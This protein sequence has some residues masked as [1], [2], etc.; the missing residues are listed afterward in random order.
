MSTTIIKLIDNNIIGAV[1]APNGTAHPYFDDI[2]HKLEPIRLTRSEFAA[3]KQFVGMIGP[4][5]SGK[6]T[7]INSLIGS[8]V[9][10]IGGGT[11]TTARPSLV[12][13][14]RNP[15]IEVYFAKNDLAN[16]S[17]EETCSLIEPFIENLKGKL[18]EE[19]LEK[20]TSELECSKLSLSPTSLKGALTG[21]F[22]K[23]PLLVVV[24]TP[25]WVL[26]TD[27]LCFVDFPGLDGFKHNYKNSPNSFA[28]MQF[29]DF[30]I[31]NQS[32]F[33]C[34]DRNMVQFLSKS[35]NQKEKP[36]VWL[37]HNKV[38]AKSWREEQSN[39]EEVNLMIAQAK[40]VLAQELEIDESEL[41]VN[42]I[43]LGKAHDGIFST[44]ESLFHESQFENFESN[45][46]GT[47]HS[48]RLEK[49]LCASKEV[50]KSLPAIRADIEADQAKCIHKENA[51]HQAQDILQKSDLGVETLAAAFGK[52]GPIN[53]NQIL[54]HLRSMM[55]ADIDVSMAK[56]K[57]ESAKNNGKL[58]ARNINKI[59]E[60]M[61]KH[62]EDSLKGF[63][64][65]DV[66]YLADPCCR[67]LDELSESVEG[68]LLD[69]ANEKLE[70]NGLRKLNPAEKWMPSDLPK[71][72]F[73]KLRW[74]PLRGTKR[75]FG[76][77]PWPR[78]Y[79][80]NKIEDYVFY[81][82]FQNLMEQNVKTL[83]HWRD[84]IKANFLKLTNDKRKKS[85]LNDLGELRTKLESEI[86]A[87]RPRF[88]KGLQ[89]IDDIESSIRTMRAATESE[90]GALR[91]K[92]WSA[93]G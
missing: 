72:P 11:E 63:A 78:T 70:K 21:P 88:S 25:E 66:P 56:L 20:A 45:F 17:L 6:S 35:L 36:P 71:I 23:E 91:N 33:A 2:Y 67:S 87:E 18:S 37:V 79:S 34:L 47:L 44:R 49:L 8:T 40:K 26:K 1:P 38:E 13:Y 83:D 9:S 60:N 76:I 27:Q 74:N 52:Y 84:S 4:G 73:N 22:P 5:R 65:T 42:L 16:L 61:V 19:D 39:V 82:M 3:R 75:V 41:P 51:I 77:I 43:N 58:A 86:Q 28:L 62:I 69:D 57:E 10:P 59:L 50:M 85:Y 48:R 30:L 89:T 46:L 54:G 7:L 64:W 32:T 55:Q 31:V 81:Q 90:L 68:Q 14:S 80:Y 15:G 24:K 12:V 53:L 93:K 29:M 92:K